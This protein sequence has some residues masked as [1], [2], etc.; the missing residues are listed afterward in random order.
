MPPDSMQEIYYRE[1]DRFGP[2]CKMLWQSFRISRH[3]EWV[4]YHKPF[5]T[6]EL[7]YTPENTLTQQIMNHVQEFFNVFEKQLNLMQK[8]LEGYSIIE[9]KMENF[10][11][12]LQPLMGFVESNKDAVRLVSNVSD[13]T[14]RILMRSFKKVIEKFNVYS[15]CF[16]IK[17]VKGFPNEERMLE[18]GRAGLREGNVWAGIV[19]DNLH[20]ATALPKF[21]AYRLRMSSDLAQ[22]TRTEKEI[23]WNYMPASGYVPDMKHLYSGQDFLMDVIEKSI[24]KAQSGP[25]Y[26]QTGI[27]V[28]PFPT[29]TYYHSE[30]NDTDFYV[31]VYCL[32]IVFVFAYL[33]T[34]VH[35]IYLI[36]YEKGWGIKFYMSFFRVTDLLS[37]PAWFICA[38]TIGIL[39]SIVPILFTCFML[40]NSSASLIIFIFFSYVVAT[41]IYCFTMSTIFFQA[42]MAGIVGG[43]M[44]LST[45]LPYFPLAFSEYV[46]LK[47]LLGLLFH[48]VTLGFIC[49]SLV[50]W[51]YYGVGAHWTNIDHSPEMGETYNVVFGIMMFYI[52][53]F[54]H[55]VCAVA[56]NK[57]YPGKHFICPGVLVSCSRN[58]AIPDEFS[59]KIE[60]KEN[61]GKGANDE[62]MIKFHQVQ[63]KFPLCAG[64]LVSGMFSFP[65]N[66]HDVTCILGYPRTWKSCLVYSICRL[67]QPY[68]GRVTYQGIPP[69]TRESL[70][71][72]IGLCPLFEP[73]FCSLNVR[74]H[75]WFYGKLQGC[76]PV[77]AQTAG[78]TNLSKLKFYHSNIKRVG[79]LG[80]NNARKLTVALSLI[81]NCDLLVFDEPTFGVDVTAQRDIWCFL[82]GIRQKTIVLTSSASREAMTISDKVI[83]I[84]TQGVHCIGSP[85]FTVKILGSDPTLVFIRRDAP[86]V[87]I[88]NENYLYKLDQYLGEK[89]KQLALVRAEDMQVIYRIP[90]AVMNAKKL[91]ALFDDL[92]KDK[93]E[94]GLVDF[95]IHNVDHIDLGKTVLRT[96]EQDTRSKKKSGVR[97]KYLANDRE[98]ETANTPTLRKGKLHASQMRGIFIKNV[99]AS[100][101]LQILFGAILL[102]LILVSLG[103]VIFKCLDGTNWGSAK[104]IQLVP[105]RYGLGQIV[106]YANRVGSDPFSQR[107]LKEFLYPPHYS[108][109]CIKYNG[110]SLLECRKNY[111]GDHVKVDDDIITKRMKRQANEKDYGVCNLQDGEPP[112]VCKAFPKKPDYETLTNGDLIEDLSTFNISDYILR[113]RNLGNKYQRLYGVE[114][115]GSNNLYGY[116]FENMQHFAKF[117]DQILTNNSYL[118]RTVLGLPSEFFRL[119]ATSHPLLVSPNSVVIWFE[120][121]AYHILPISINAVNN[122]VLRA[123]KAGSP[124]HDQYA[125]A[126]YSH[127]WHPLFY[128]KEQHLYMYPNI[129]L[130]D[131][132]YMEALAILPCYFFYCLAYENVSGAKHLYII[133]GLSTT[134][135]WLGNYCSHFICF[136]IPAT[137]GIIGLGCL[138]RLDYVIEAIPL[139]LF[140]GL[141]VFP[142]LYLHVFVVR[143]ARTIFY[144][145]LAF[146]IVEGVGL[147]SLSMY[148]ESHY[149]LASR[150]LKPFFLIF[151]PYGL[152]GGILELHYTQFKLEKYQDST[153]YFRISTA[154]LFVMMLGI[155]AF[156]YFILL[157]IFENRIDSKQN[158]HVQAVTKD[159][160][161]DDSANPGSKVSDIRPF[162]YRL[163]NAIDVR[164]VRKEYKVSGCH[165]S[166]R[167]A[168]DNLRFSVPSMSCVCMFGDAKGGKTT[169]IEMIVSKSDITSGKI[170]LYGS[171][172]KVFYGQ[173]IN[174]QLVSFCPQSTVALDPH[175]NAIHLYWFVARVKGIEKANIPV[176][177]N[178][179]ISLLELQ[180]IET[181][182]A[183]RLS[184]D[185]RRKVIF[186]IALIGNSRLCILDEPL[187]RVDPKVKSVIKDALRI[188]SS[189]GKTI[190]MTSNLCEGMESD[191]NSNVI[192]A[193]VV[194]SH[195][196]SIMRGNR[197]SLMQDFA[198]YVV[199]WVIFSTNAVYAF[200]LALHSNFDQTRILERLP[201]R[202]VYRISK[203]SSSTVSKLIKFMEGN[204]SGR[205]RSKSQKRGAG[206]V[207]LRYTISDPTLELLVYYAVLESYE[208]MDDCKNPIVP[209]NT[210]P[211]DINLSQSNASWSGY[212]SK[213][214]ISAL[215]SIRSDYENNKTMPHA[216]SFLADQNAGSDN[217]HLSADISKS[218]DNSDNRRLSADAS[219]GFNGRSV[220]KKDS[221]SRKNSASRSSSRLYSVSPTGSKKGF[222]K[223]PGS[224]KESVVQ[225][226]F[227]KGS[228]SPAGSKKGSITPVET[229]KSSVTPVEMKRVSI[230]PNS[231]KKDS[232]SKKADAEYTKHRRRSKR[233]STRNSKEV[234][235]IEPSKSPTP[236]ESKT[237]EAKR[238]A[239]AP[240]K[241]RGSKTSE[242]SE[243]EY[244]SDS[245]EK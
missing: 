85:Q 10:T 105:W 181:K 182:S 93:D 38:F 2:M 165:R 135:Y 234:A 112:A 198:N 121:K 245:D 216:E 162:L 66:K 50:Q 29:P 211:P 134:V 34:V 136:L 69:K 184:E 19:F 223:R 43:L 230:A 107:L 37:W 166:E 83:A 229:K 59:S 213:P 110:K 137:I 87:G 45:L 224:K 199:L 40:P 174:R 78:Q 204:T 101:N 7:Y 155:D 12:S 109:G 15:Q 79:R 118:N 242:L 178:W 127:P 90:R 108:T 82:K 210:P 71:D 76:D 14:W 120:N 132:F 233:R 11:T 187:S 195:R 89:F 68:K 227:K 124:E 8:L 145:L 60:D 58:T 84:S 151:P 148:F 146:L 113:K 203:L 173:T 97:N 142:F 48:N 179:V 172:S 149:P 226:E 57:A 102:P 13:S 86:N 17:R 32:P 72:E 159:D 26:A 177:L 111:D 36:V 212:G 236:I 53:S 180:D 141:A 196:Q 131:F 126:A 106:A 218:F 205:R 104:A 140:Y 3:E 116:N 128:E 158:V 163:T 81:N 6:G 51:E 194:L 21:I 95:V 156:V 160:Q 35:F 217:R 123:T 92:A 62:E 139:I 206:N 56:L 240:P 143:D 80:L 154:G 244:L 150:I 231:L 122:I 5:F 235:K 119:N 183:W 64:P 170:I 100:L 189:K 193:A 220:S 147:A 77:K 228:V 30:H 44:F 175:L 94:L 70:Y 103:V 176:V 88:A 114:F 75:F 153:G 98:V 208:Y 39:S 219:R 22:D 237:S 243:Y 222:L 74:R 28:Q 200:N 239:T 96:K 185:E 201:G 73:L 46:I 225:E 63:F 214:P 117:L 41:I 188:L 221:V 9:A 23:P 4:K 61:R 186:G 125:I 1:D 16:L 133:H 144:V 238:R 171:D 47:I 161:D 25:N 42:D 191:Y 55:I 33:I 209:K 241:V 190:F 152:C 129:L 169:T 99:Y 167:L 168:V 202:A 232:V 18:E 20:N 31:L 115:L 197:A 52:N 207:V 65:C 138:R 130:L 67:I 215:A 27:Y 91:A 54:L 192:E 164:K 24:I 157:L 49:E